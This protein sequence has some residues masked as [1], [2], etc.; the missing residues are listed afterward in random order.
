MEAGQRLA[1]RVRSG[2]GETPFPFPRLPSRSWPKAGRPPSDNRGSDEWRLSGG[3]TPAHL[4]KA[5]KGIILGRWVAGDK[6]GSW[7]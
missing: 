4:P 5:A 1:R 3:W 6:E 7:R 2:D